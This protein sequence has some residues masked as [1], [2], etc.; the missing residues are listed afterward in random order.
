MKQELA[1]FDFDGTLTTRDS[2][3]LFMQKTR[4]AQLYPAMLRLSI[5]SA[6]TLVGGYS[7][8]SLKR[9]FLDAL[10]VGMGKEE[11]CTL[12]QEFYTTH[13]HTILRSKG[14]A[15]IAKHKENDAR[16]IV[17]TASPRLL[18]EPFCKT[19]GIECLGTELEF[20]E[21]G[22]FTGRLA[23]ANCRKEEKVRRIEGH[24]RLADFSTIY[25]YGDSDG[26]T[27]M[28][29]L[30]LPENRHYKPFRK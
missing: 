2:F 16:V 21:K 22:K 6:L 9:Q 29:Q 28:F 11:F 15:E 1:L 27:E 24:L 13:I 17:V 26:D 18:V 10:F 23:S 30:A 3:L 4:P 5:H 20:D 8:E 12:C 25:V 7:R 19:Q 14:I